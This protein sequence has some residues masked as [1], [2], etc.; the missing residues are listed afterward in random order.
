MIA[1]LILLLTIT[2][3]CKAACYTTFQLIKLTTQTCNNTAVCT[4]YF[5]MDE[6]LKIVGIPTQG[7]APKVWTNVC[8][9]RIDCSSNATIT[10]DVITAFQSFFPLNAAWYDLVT[11]PFYNIELINCVTPNVSIIFNLYKMVANMRQYT[12]SVVGSGIVSMDLALLLNYNP[13]P[14]GRT[15]TVN[16]SLLLFNLS[17]NEIISITNSTGEFSPE[18][19]QCNNIR[20]L[21]FLDILDLGYNNISREEDLLSLCCI[22]GPARLFLQNNK[23][24]LIS[25]ITASCLASNLTELNVAS[26]GIQSLKNWTLSQLTHLNKLDMSNN[27]LT[28]VTPE[29]FPISLQLLNLRGNLL[30][31]CQI[32]QPFLSRSIVIDI[33]SICTT[34]ISKVFDTSTQFIPK[35]S[36]PQSSSR[37]PLSP[38]SP[39][40]SLSQSPSQSS[41]QAIISSTNQQSEPSLI[42]QT[43]VEITMSPSINQDSNKSTVFSIGQ[44]VGAVIG[45]FAA[46]CLLVLIIILIIY[47]R[48]KKKS[49]EHSYQRSVAKNATSSNTH[50]II[51]KANNQLQDK[52]AL[53]VPAR[54]VANLNGNIQN[55]PYEEIDLTSDEPT[56]AITENNPVYNS[57]TFEIKP[58]AAAARPYLKIQPENNN[59]NTYLQL[60]LDDAIYKDPE[61]KWKTA[62][63]LP[64]VTIDNDPVYKQ[65]DESDEVHKLS[66]DGHELQTKITDET[67]PVY[68]DAFATDV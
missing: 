24:T 68:H 28:A 33:G 6:F 36:P 59:D 32:F 30:L 17:H 23:I 62:E 43:A 41:A 38:L 44:M 39:T 37:Q 2:S 50:N 54:S 52:L 29:M 35:P 49:A 48:N 40:L 60:V 19:V 1:I 63:L 65:Y 22:N 13:N 11:Q 55:Q 25:N 56:Y 61:K 16:P 66:A 31:D 9:L 4:D 21:T 5:T 8:S 26:N 58:V 10:Q 7:Y 46:T 27:R 64:V 67:S 15:V 20:Q 3:D 42:T 47:L 51:P 57:T 34:I 53:N 14:T 18:T 12:F 45:T